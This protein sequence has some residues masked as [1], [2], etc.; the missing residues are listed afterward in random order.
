MIIPE[1]FY[2]P[3]VRDGFYVPSEMKRYWAAMLEVYDQV[4]R[5]CRKHGLNFYADYGTLIGAVR[6]AGSFHGMM[7]LISQ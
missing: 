5:V 6:H 3:E 2:E 1:K 4:A 7:I